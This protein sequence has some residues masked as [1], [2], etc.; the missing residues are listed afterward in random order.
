MSSG[1]IEAADTA[2]MIQ[3]LERLLNDD[4]FLDDEIRKEITQYDNDGNLKIDRQEFR[5]MLSSYLG[6]IS[7]DESTELFDDIDKDRS[8]FIEVHELK[9]VLRLQIM[10]ELDRLKKENGM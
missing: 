4:S 2:L 5:A 3:V 8:G 1:D 10:Q 6:T 7:E 9:K